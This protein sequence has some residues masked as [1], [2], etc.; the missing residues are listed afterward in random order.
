MVLPSLLLLLDVALRTAEPTPAEPWQ[1][2]SQAQCGETSLKIVQPKYP[3]DLAPT[4]LANGKDISETTGLASELG[5]RAAAYRFS[6]VCSP[7]DHVLSLRWIKGKAAGDGTVSYD[8]GSISIRGAEVLSV[9]A[10]PSSEDDFWY[11]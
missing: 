1:T 4:I 3:L 10:E 8:S 2:T 7:S 9:M 11:R 6:F 5:D